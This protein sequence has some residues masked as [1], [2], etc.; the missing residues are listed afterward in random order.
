M[1][2]CPGLCQLARKSRPAWP[3]WMGVTWRR[4]LPA[5]PAGDRL[6]SYPPGVISSSVD[7]Q[8]IP[9]PAAWK[10]GKSL[11][12]AML[13]RHVQDHNR[14]PDNIG[15]IL[16]ASPTMRSKGDDVAEILWLMGLKPKWQKGSGNVIGLAVIPL[17]EL[18]RPRLDV[19]PRISG[20]FRDA[21]PNVVEL[22]DKGV[23]MIAALKEKPSMNYL[24][25]HVLD[26][27]A[28]YKNDGM[29]EDD[30]FRQATLRLFGAP[31][32]AYGA[33]VARSHRGQELERHPRYR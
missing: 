6:R 16:W 4:V 24:R 23:Q 5:R 29:S 1:T 32:G 33:G 18:G 25:A 14:Y 7:P 28:A 17:E 26:D 2:C 27:M 31:P 13:E 11:G 22:L 9:T 20:I 10:V 12:E 8:K 15:F 3:L 30:A 19:T 21:F